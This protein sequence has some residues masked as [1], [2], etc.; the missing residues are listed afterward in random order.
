MKPRYVL[1]TTAA[2]LALAAPM[3]GCSTTPVGPASMPDMSFSQMQPVELNVSAV[4]VV[5]SSGNTPTNPRVSPVDALTRYANRRLQAVGGEGALNF[6]I[7]QASLTSADRERNMAGSAISTGGGRSRPR[8][9]ASSSR[10]TAAAERASAP[11][12]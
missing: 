2:L 8:C 11:M 10:W 4:R 7:Q 9:L 1:L 6:V 3:A 12:P 5:D